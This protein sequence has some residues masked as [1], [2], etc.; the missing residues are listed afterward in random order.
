MHGHSDFGNFQAFQLPASAIRKAEDM[1]ALAIVK[2][3][4]KAPPAE[5]EIIA[6]NHPSKT[7]A[8]I[9]KNG[10][11]VATIYESGGMMTPNDVGTPPDLANDGADL[12]ERR[13]QQM[14]EMIGGT[15]SYAKPKAASPQSG[16][17]AATLFLAQMS[18]G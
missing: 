6:D 9:E 15:I 10:R 5:H 11:V 4:A 2:P 8:T 7:Y 17:S 14:Q 1:E 16:V 12:A 3:L 13:L 18:K